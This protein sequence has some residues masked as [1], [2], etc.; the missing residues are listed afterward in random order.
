VTNELSSDQSVEA[1]SWDAL[2]LARRLGG[3]IL[4]L[5]AACGGSSASS[6]SMS[7]LPPPATSSVVE[8]TTMSTLPPRWDQWSR[9]LD[10]S[11]VSAGDQEMRDVAVVGST[12]VAVGTHHS[13]EADDPS[14]WD[15]SVWVSSDGINWTRVLNEP[16][17]EVAGYQAMHSVVAGGPGFV[18]VGVDNRDADSDAAVW[19]SPDGWTWTRVVHDEAIFGGPDMQAMSAVASGPLGVVAVGEDVPGWRA[20]VW[21]SPD[22]LTW[23]RV[24]HDESLFGSPAY[25]VISDVVA[26]G[27]RFWAVGSAALSGSDV[28]AVWISSDGVTWERVPHDEDAFGI[29]RRRMTA[30]ASFS[31]GLVAVGIAAGGRAIVWT[32]QDGT[33]W[34]RISDSDFGGLSPYG[35]SSAMYGV[36][37][38]HGGAV[39]VGRSDGP[40]GDSQAAVWGSDDGLWWQRLAVFVAPGDQQ[41]N[42]VV[43]FDGGAI[44]VGSDSSSGDID[45]AVWI[46]LEDG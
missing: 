29:I 45:A 33:D 32:S 16:S 34:P 14:G 13:G 46:W 38:L 23:T 35:G 7:T 3:L 17:L 2:V 42:S 22:G 18:A 28:A 10:G 6:S 15:A 39:A 43:L 25:P 30:I 26:V 4:L 21:F 11:L 20:A 9:V 8:S 12:L 36:V 41:A 44:A 19:T 24:P 31:G 40:D 1:L 5:F 27:D 37:A